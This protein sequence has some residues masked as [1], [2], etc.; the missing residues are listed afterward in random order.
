MEFL[1]HGVQATRD[2]LVTLG[3]S[4]IRIDDA[5]WKVLFNILDKTKSPGSPYVNAGI[6]T[7]GSF[8]EELLRN[9]VEE[10]LWSLYQADAETV[11]NMTAMEC[12]IEGLCDPAKVHVKDELT[13]MSKVARLIYGA[14]VV[15]RLVWQLLM[16]DY[17]VALPQ[18]A[19]DKRSCSAIGIDFNKGDE[20]RSGVQG[21]AANFSEGVN[22]S[23]DDVEGWEYMVDESMQAAYHTAWMR[24][25]CGQYGPILRKVYATFALIDCKAP[26]VVLS[27]GRVFEF[28]FHIQCSGKLNTHNGNTVLR[29]SVGSICLYDEYQYY[30]TIE[31]GCDFPMPTSKCNGD[32]YLGAANQRSALNYAMLGFVLKPEVVDE[33]AFSFSSH[34][35]SQGQCYLE[36]VRKPLANYASSTFLTESEGQVPEAHLVRWSLDNEFKTLPPRTRSQVT[37]LMDSIQMVRTRLG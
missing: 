25:S 7:I 26:A 14:S 12:A 20:F 30:P 31:L 29:A 35:F 6:C 28:P 5:A 2:D 8:P 32:D 10:R 1:C 15:D 34:V 4:R 24:S 3:A 22:L 18:K 19:Y 11:K 13:K 9:C 37:F 36:T 16:H 23:S 27:N 33:K 17:L 21:I